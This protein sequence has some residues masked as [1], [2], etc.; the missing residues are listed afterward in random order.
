MLHFH[1]AAVPA[2]VRLKKVDIDPSLAAIRAPL[3]GAG[4]HAK[5]GD[6]GV[7]KSWLIAT[8][9]E[10][11]L[12]GPY[13]RKGAPISGALTAPPGEGGGATKKWANG[14]IRIRDYV[15][16]RWFSGAA[17]IC[18]DF[19]ARIAEGPHPVNRRRARR[20][21]FRALI[22]QAGCLFLTPWIE[23]LITSKCG[24]VGGIA[25]DCLGRI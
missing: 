11:P 15:H 16:G 1:D 6:T 3:I 10:D 18:R 5:P 2:L 14:G 12:F 21:S 24:I 25:L 7:G 13:S 20:P 17:A 4:W 19:M 8:A 9:P 23:D 22:A